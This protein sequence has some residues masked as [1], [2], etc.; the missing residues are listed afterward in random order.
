M[1]VVQRCVRDVDAE[2]VHVQIMDRPRPHRPAA[3]LP[4][5]HSLGRDP[6][7]AGDLGVADTGGEQFSGAPSAALEPIALRG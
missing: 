5:T 2:W 3:G 4:D 6:E 7:P 1:Q